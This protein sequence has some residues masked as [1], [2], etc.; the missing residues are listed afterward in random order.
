MRDDLTQAV[1]AREDV[2]RYLRSAHGDDSKAARERVEGYLDELRTTQR[3]SIYKAL[4]HPLYPIFRKITRID[5]NLQNVIS[6]TAK[7]QVVYVSA[8]FHGRGPYL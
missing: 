5:E 7:G 4:K 6:A 8:R 2:A 3:Y 1:L